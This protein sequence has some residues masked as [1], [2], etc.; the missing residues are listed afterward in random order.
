MKNYE[1]PMILNMGTYEGVYAASGD[2]ADNGG[3]DNN[4]PVCDS[5]Y[6]RG[7]FRQ[8]DYSDWQYGT[9]LN[10]RGCE[11]CPAN[12]SDGKCH[13]ASYPPAE[14]CRPSWEVQGQ[15]PDWRWNEHPTY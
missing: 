2:V 9:N 12:W 11:G 6:I 3:E 4:Q 15:Q 10:G 1:K 7:N 14:D 13:V 8:P 5:I